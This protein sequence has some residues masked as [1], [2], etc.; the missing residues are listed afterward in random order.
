VIGHIGGWILNVAALTSFADRTVY[1]ESVLRVAR[2]HALTLLVPDSALYDAYD[3]RPNG[4]PQLARLLSEPA[5]WLHDR[6]EVPCDAMS[7]F[8][9]MAG[10]DT[11]AAHVA[12]L[13]S[14]RGWPV[15]TDNSAAAALQRIV[16]DLWIV[17]A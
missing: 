2:T 10:G 12:Y 16:P 8:C 4:G 15:L 6:A 14:K 17:P 13:G 3:A 5:T 1:A 7:Q 9:H 11:T